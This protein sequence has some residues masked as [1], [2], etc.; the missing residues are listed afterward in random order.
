L[1]LLFAFLHSPHFKIEETPL[2]WKELQ[3]W[4]LEIRKLKSTG[5]MLKYQ[6]NKMKKPRCLLFQVQTPEH[7]HQIFPSTP[8][9][10]LVICTNYYKLI[11]ALETTE[12]IQYIFHPKDIASAALANPT[13][14]KYLTPLQTRPLRYFSKIKYLQHSLKKG[15]V[16]DI[17]HTQMYRSHNQMTI[18]LQY[19]IAES[20]G[21]YNLLIIFNNY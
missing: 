17:K 6:L 7:S 16:T 5:K 8:F 11:S 14:S 10:I 19:L 2:N 4:D 15:V 3:S 20:T 21:L 18:G 1:D 12:G 13:L 9:K